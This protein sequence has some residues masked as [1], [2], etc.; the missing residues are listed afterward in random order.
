MS[1]LIHISNAP[2][3][4]VGDVFTIEGIRPLIANPD[5]RWWQFWKPRLIENPDPEILQMFKVVNSK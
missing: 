2:N 5:R 4:K 3:I 1:D